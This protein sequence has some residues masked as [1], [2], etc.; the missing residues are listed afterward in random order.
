MAATPH[1]KQGISGG[2]QA[3]G[4]S[5]RPMKNSIDLSKFQEVSKF[6]KLDLIIK[7]LNK[8]DP[9]SLQRSSRR[10]VFMTWR[11]D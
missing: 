6:T 11:C 2:G 10:S 1:R 8:I 9:I 7:F 5:R 4:I 3:K